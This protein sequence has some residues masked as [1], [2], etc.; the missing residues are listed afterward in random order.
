MFAKT[1]EHGDYCYNVNLVGDNDE[2]QWS[3]NLDHISPNGV[4]NGLPAYEV[5][6]RNW[7]CVGPVFKSRSEGARWLGYEGKGDK[8]REHQDQLVEEYSSL[9]S[10]E[11]ETR[12]RFHPE[13]KPKFGRP[14]QGRDRR[15]SFYTSAKVESWLGSQRQ[16]NEALS[17][18]IHRV[19]E[20]RARG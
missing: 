7:Q 2:F 16:G 15:L 10:D 17:N 19:L 18:V 14:S 8:V 4:G 1:T 20:E 6:N 3:I 11:I 5:T 12:E 13:N 9:Y